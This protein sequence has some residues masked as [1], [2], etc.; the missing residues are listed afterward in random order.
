[1]DEKSEEFESEEAGVE[2]PIPFYG[3]IFYH[4]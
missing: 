1:V 4:A 2:E 3:T